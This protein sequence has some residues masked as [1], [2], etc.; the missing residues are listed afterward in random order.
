MC[1][2]MKKIKQLL[3]LSTILILLVGVASASE[4]SEDK[5]DTGSITEE[6]VTQDTHKVSDTANNIQENKANENIQTNR[7]INKI[8]KNTIETKK[9]AKNTKKEEVITVNNWREL[10]NVIE[11]SKYKQENFTVKLGKGTYTDNEAIYCN[12][13]KILYF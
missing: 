5:T 10:L 2:K 12:N 4:V 13:N 9:A 3:L 11:S 7:S 1:K 6:A 8:D